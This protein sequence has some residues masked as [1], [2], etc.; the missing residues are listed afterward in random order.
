M[1]PET[2]MLFSGRATGKHLFGVTRCEQYVGLFVVFS[3]I[4]GVCAPCGWSAGFGFL[5]PVLAIPLWCALAS[6][7]F[8]AGLFSSA[9]G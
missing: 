8:P 2:V 1:S 5:G 9:V 6:L 3:S 7:G 4:L